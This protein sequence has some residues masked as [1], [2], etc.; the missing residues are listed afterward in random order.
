MEN[1]IVEFLTSN[2]KNNVVIA[3][4]SVI[5]IGTIVMLF[6][7]NKKISNLEDKIK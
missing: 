6:R 1:K 3:V 5:L 2:M 4:L 7:M